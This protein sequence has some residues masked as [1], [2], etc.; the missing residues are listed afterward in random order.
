V[1]SRAI[2][3]LSLAADIANDFYT[4]RSEAVDCINKEDWKLFIPH[5]SKRYVLDSQKLGMPVFKVM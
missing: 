5:F 1:F 4:F 2:K 3:V